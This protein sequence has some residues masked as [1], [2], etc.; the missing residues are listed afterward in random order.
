MDEPRR[1]FCHLDGV[2]KTVS[3][4]VTWQKASSPSTTLVG[5][6]RRE[7]VMGDGKKDFSIYDLHPKGKNFEPEETYI[8]KTVQTLGDHFGGHVRDSRRRDWKVSR[9][10]RERGSESHEMELIETSHD[11]MEALHLESYW[12]EFLGAG[13]N[14][15]RPGKQTLCKGEE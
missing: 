14:T 12:C 8:G 7:W 10:I 1:S 4:P 13:L 3:T 6:E 11:S 2:T 5:G 15:R 9:F